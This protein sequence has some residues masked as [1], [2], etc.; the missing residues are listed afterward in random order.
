MMNLTNTNQ[1]VGYLGP[2]GKII[3]IG[4]DQIK[5]FQEG[6][7]G[8]FWMTPQELIVTKLIQHDKTQYKYK[9]KTK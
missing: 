6:G 7:N 2:H 8:P 4:D 9:T 1:E 5:V 3:D